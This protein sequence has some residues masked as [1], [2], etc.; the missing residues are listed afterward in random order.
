VGWSVTGSWFDINIRK[1][2][3][4]VGNQEDVLIE[5]ILRRSFAMGDLTE[6]IPMDTKGNLQ[7]R[8]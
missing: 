3:D 7:A 1:E 8:K 5:K 2:Y 4:P 6:R